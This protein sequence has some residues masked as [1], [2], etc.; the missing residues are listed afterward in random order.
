[1]PILPTTCM[2]CGSTLE[3]SKTEVDLYCLNENCLA[4]SGRQLTHFFGMLNNLDGFGPKTVEILINNGFDTI[5]KIYEMKW[6]DFKMCG[7]GDKTTMNLG[8][9]LESSLERELPD[10]RFIAA[11]GIPDLGISGAKNLLEH[12]TYSDIL[13]NIT[14]NDVM[15]IDGFGYN[16]C[17]SIFNYIKENEGLIISIYDLD[18]N[19]IHEEIKVK[20]SQFT[21]KRMCFTGKMANNRGTMEG[22]ARGLGATITGVNSKTDILVCGERVGVNKIN[23]AKKFDVKTITEEEFISIAGFTS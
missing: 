9:E 12:Y 18:F 16:K 2:D 22:F 10:Y 7:F 14:P 20:E 17:E 1:M 13:F 3:W 11:L 19:I 21:G 8:S 23:A 15:V 6:N 4:R 5:P